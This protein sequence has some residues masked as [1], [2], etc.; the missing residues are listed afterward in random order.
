MKRLP[1]AALAAACLAGPAVAEP[2]PEPVAVSGEFHRVVLRVPLRL[3]VTE[4]ETAVSVAAEP[5]VRERLRIQVRGDDL[6]IDSERDLPWRSRGLVAVRMKEFRGLR[7]DGS[8]DAEVTAGP[9]PRS[10]SL[11]VRGSGDVTF[12]GAAKALA[13]EIAGSGDVR[14]QADAESVAIEVGG[15]GNVVYSGRAG[16][17]KVEISGSGNVKLGGSGASL[18]AETNGSG[19]VDASGFPVSRASVE[20]HGSG[21]VSVRLEGGTLRARISG[22]GDVTWSGSGSVAEATV[23][24]SG[25]VRRR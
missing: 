8:G 3:E 14:A 9:A 1:L 18:T 6:V 5:E 2:A 19:D 22:S 21:N 16:S 20:T 11:R 12:R 24:G 10:V 7:V 15:S 13:I 23:S 4:G 25:E 17:A